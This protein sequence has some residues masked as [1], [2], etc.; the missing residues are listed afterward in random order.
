M[1][2]LKKLTSFSTSKTPNFQFWGRALPKV[3]FEVIAILKEF[4]HFISQVMLSTPQKLSDSL[5]AA[6]MDSLIDDVG[7]QGVCMVQ[8]SLL[9]L[10]SYHT[11]SGII[12]DIGNR[13]E[14]LPI[15]DG[16]YRRKVAVDDA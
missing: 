11:T 5:R 9:A 10:Y 7:V 12:V 2:D 13:I 16:E 6:L 4:L 3:A 15:Y 1:E 14:I 8:Q